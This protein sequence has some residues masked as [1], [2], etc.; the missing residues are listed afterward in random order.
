MSYVVTTTPKVSDLV[1]DPF[2]YS[3]TLTQA[4][5]AGCLADATAEG[6][7]RVLPTAIA[8]LDAIGD[9]YGAMALDSLYEQLDS[10]AIA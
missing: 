3:E 1:L 5:H 6:L 4:L 9:P 2:V 10:M 7:A 8:Q